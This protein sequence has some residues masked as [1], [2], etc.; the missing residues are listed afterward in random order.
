MRESGLTTFANSTLGNIARYWH[1]YAE[2]ILLIGCFLLPLKLS[3]T[4]LFFGPA[5]IAWLCSNLSNIGPKIK[6]FKWFFIPWGMFIFSLFLHAF[7]GFNPGRSLQ[8]FYALI[9]YPIVLIAIADTFCARRALLPL[10][11]LV[12]GQS[13]AGIHSVL[14]ISCAGQLPRLFLGAVTESGQLA[15]VVPLACGLAVT[16]HRFSK[17]KINILNQIRRAG[18]AAIN[19][20]LLCLAAFSSEL[21]STSKNT[22]LALVIVVFVIMLLSLRSQAEKSSLIENIELERFK[23]LLKI[24]LKFLEGVFLPILLAALVVNLKRGPWAGVIIALILFSL[25]YSRK[26]VVPLIAAI[27]A[28]VIVAIPVQTR[29]LESSRDF[30]IPGGRSAIWRVGIELAERFPLGIGF[31]NS[32]FLHSYSA[33]I[34]AELTHF[35]NNAINILVEAGPLTLILYIVWIISIVRF[36]F[37]AK[38]DPILAP[39]AKAIGVAL[40]AWQVAGLVEYNFGDSEVVFIVYVLLGALAGLQKTIRNTENSNYS[41][42]ST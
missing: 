14:D 39:T 42:V 16:L 35:H 1:T 9:F 26:L 27:A 33:E 19:T 23:I 31:R 8:N 7:F 24:S 2:I 17:T 13:L 18:L 22:S 32:K 3:F 10:L 21:F 15:L 34:P 5:I 6:E 37:K 30:F 41:T 38:I 11:T 25:I 20:A 28:I 12:L 40:I 36:A 4:Y 29:L